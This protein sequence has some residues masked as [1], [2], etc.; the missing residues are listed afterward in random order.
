MRRKKMKKADE[1]QKIRI[2]EYQKFLQIK[3]FPKYEKAD[4][5]EKRNFP[6]NMKI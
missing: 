2:Y 4:Q 3:E 6:E 5:R 1:R